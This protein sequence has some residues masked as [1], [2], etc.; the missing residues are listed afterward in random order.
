M[1]GAERGAR[2]RILE[3]GCSGSQALPREGGWEC[4]GT[5]SGPH[6]PVGLV[7]HVSACAEHMDGSIEPP[8][9]GNSAPAASPF[10]HA[11]RA[12]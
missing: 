3:G 5:S 12:L 2:P 4:P 6:R 1:P 9:T 8:V 11:V 7:L 10:T